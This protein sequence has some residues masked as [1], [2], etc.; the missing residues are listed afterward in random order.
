MEPR[1]IFFDFDST[2]APTERLREIRESAD[3]D[4]LTP[5]VLQEIR[6][7]RPIPAL[8]E[9]LRSQGAKLGV[10]TNAGKGYITRLFKHLDLEGTF[11]TV[12]TYT[13]VKAIGMKPSPAG[14]ELALERLGV[15]ANPRIL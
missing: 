6:L 4:A 13:D 3:Y 8:I 9:K 12:V 11:D 15:K 7:Y 5:E 14:I 2:L 10:V 1:V